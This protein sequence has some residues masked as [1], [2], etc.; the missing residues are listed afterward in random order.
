MRN[1]LLLVMAAL[2]LSVTPVPSV[3]LDSSPNLSELKLVTQLPAELPQRVM[4]FAFDG[5]KLWATVYHG[6][7]RYA[8]LD[9]ATL[10]WK[11]KLL[12]EHD[13]LIGRVANPR[14]SPGGICFG[15]GKLWMS[16]G[17]GE[18][19]ASIDTQTLKVEELITGK[20]RQDHHASQSYSSLAFDGN[21]LWVV[22]HWFRY[23]LPVWQTQLLLKVDLQGGQVLAEYP[24]PAGTRPDGAH[25]LTWDGTR[26]WHVKDNRLSS[27]DPTTGE[28]TAK[29]QLAHLKRPSGLAW[30]K[31]SLWIVEF[32][33]KV[34]QLPFAR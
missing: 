7:G 16:G 9:P 18:S 15:Q 29:Y 10:T 30:V 4:G 2:I 6:D 27:I 13:D 32:N 25:G 1:L 12:R 24:A 33:G 5:E 21:Y 17:Y 31:D 23:D 3:A 20:R 34:W 22:W 28:V 14:T 19:I 11:A 8:T 26:L